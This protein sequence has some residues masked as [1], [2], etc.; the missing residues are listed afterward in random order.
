[1]VPGKMTQN[2]PKKSM[3]LVLEGERVRYIKIEGN[4]EVRGAKLCIYAKKNFLNPS[5][6]LNQFGTD[7]QTN[8][9]THKQTHKDT[10]VEFAFIYIKEV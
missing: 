8:T 6:L 2:T 9:Q 4:S 3:L 7:K 10:N 1:M 5:S